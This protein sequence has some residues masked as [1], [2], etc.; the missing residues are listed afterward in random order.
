MKAQEI[1]ESTSKALEPEFSRLQSMYEREVS[2]CELNF[3]IEERRLQENLKAQLEASIEEEKSLAKE[4]L[5][6][7]IQSI[8]DKYA[9]ELEFKIRDH[10]SKQRS[11]QDDY[12]KELEKLSNQFQDKLSRYRKKFYQEIQELQQQHQ[13]RTTDLKKS[14]LLHM[15]NIHE[16]HNETLKSIR[17]KH[18]KEKKKLE[19]YVR[20]KN[21]SGEA[22][23]IS[24]L[25]LLAQSG[26]L[27]S[28]SKSNS[29]ASLGAP[30][31]NGNTAS[32]HLQVN[33]G[34]Q[35]NIQA[36]ELEITLADDSDSDDEGVTHKDNLNA[37]KSCK[38]SEFKQKE[39]EDMD[40]NGSDQEAELHARPP[41]SPNRIMSLPPSSANP[42]SSRP[43]SAS[44]KKSMVTSSNRS[45]GSDSQKNGI[46]FTS[47]ALQ[48]RYLTSRKETESKRDRQIQSEIRQLEAETIKLERDLKIRVEHEKQSIL[49]LTKI[50]EENLSNQ[51]AQLTN[52]VTELIK[53]RESL[54]QYQEEENH[55]HERYKSEISDLKKQ[56]QIYREGLATQRDD[57]RVKEDSLRTKLRELQLEYSPLIRKI[58]NEYEELME[59][60]VDE[61][62]R[63]KEDNMVIEKNHAKELAKLDSSVSL[64]YWYVQTYLIWFN[65]FSSG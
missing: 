24:G 3:Q 20:E 13:Q 9:R 12:D 34:K 15:E 19:H 40:G 48:E 43:S 18:L 10:K 22:V 8:Q 56:I 49:S 46:R 28:P 2:D 50:E 45:A 57:L 30:S 14:H 64:D 65:V 53:E 59:S 1:K 36:E 61:E 52:E 23:D 58:K 60:I 54:F 4:E 11:L 25:I 27:P 17:R 29:N 38:T 31:P 41:I 55:R 39:S 63:W 6:Y 5:K 35:I 37:R 42:N 21:L 44:S 33:N 51:A 32:T 47:P 26:D 7:T 16:E 62:N